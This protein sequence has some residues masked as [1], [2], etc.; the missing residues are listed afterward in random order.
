MPAQFSAQTFVELRSAGAWTVSW[1][2]WRGAL[3]NL[4]VEVSAELVWPVFLGFCVLLL[5]V[6]RS[7]LKRILAALAPSSGRY[8]PYRIGHTVA[9][10]LI[11]LAL[12]LPGPVVSG[13]SLLLGMADESQIFPHA[14]AAALAA[15]ANYCW[16]LPVFA[17]LIDQNG[18]AV[19]HFG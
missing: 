15:A 10:L 17:R 6:T 2:N 9:A 4:L 1:E 19:A 8:R 7:R 5:L 13:R 11:T 18:V 3:T 14:L 12:A 16:R